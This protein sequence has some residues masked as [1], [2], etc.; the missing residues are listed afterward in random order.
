VLAGKE[1][2]QL[3]LCERGRGDVPL[4]DEALIVLEEDK[5]V[6]NREVRKR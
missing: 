1:V 3:K 4:L 2:G 6:G 5:L